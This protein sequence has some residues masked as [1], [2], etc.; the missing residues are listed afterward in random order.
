MTGIRNYRMQAPLEEWGAP[1]LLP[2]AEHLK[3]YDRFCWQWRTGFGTLSLAGLGLLALAILGPSDWFR[4]L[5]ARGVTIGGTIGIVG[6]FLAMVGWWMLLRFFFAFHRQWGLYERG[7]VAPAYR[8]GGW[9]LF[10]PWEQVKLL[11]VRRM[12]A[13]R[14]GTHREG[15]AFLFRLEDKRGRVHRFHEEVFVAY[16]GYSSDQCAKLKEELFVHFRPRLSPEQIV[17][18]AELS[19]S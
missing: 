1:L 17:V 5:N 3:R 11:K 8:K 14:K 15:E 12:V 18:E 13:H 7:F 10:V 16:F 19:A 2:D 6:F 9:D 4:P